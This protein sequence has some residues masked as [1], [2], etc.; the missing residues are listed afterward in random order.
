MV[1]QEMFYEALFSP[2]VEE[3][4]IGGFSSQVFRA[5]LQLFTLVPIQ[6]KCFPEVFSP[7]VSRLGKN[8]AI[9]GNSEDATGPI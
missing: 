3:G 5:Q 9:A 8:L 1:G 4:M 6:T 7:Q 2:H